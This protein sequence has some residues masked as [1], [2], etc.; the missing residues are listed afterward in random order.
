M[1]ILESENYNENIIHG[2]AKNET[3]NNDGGF[4][5]IYE[6]VEQVKQDVKKREYMSDNSI[7]NI[8]NILNNRKNVPFLPMRPR[9]G[10]EKI[11]IEYNKL[12]IKKTKK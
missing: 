7:M 5:P 2:G 12:N 3:P 10:K 8:H 6:V 11:N 9:T 1:K 4:P